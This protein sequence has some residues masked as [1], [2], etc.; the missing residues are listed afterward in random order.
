VDG[1]GEQQNQSTKKMIAVT[2]RMTTM[3]MAILR[4]TTPIT[5]ASSPTQ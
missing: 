3:P 5:G 1:E 2:P 4:P